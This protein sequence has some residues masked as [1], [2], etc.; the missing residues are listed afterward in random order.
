[1]DDDI[2]AIRRVLGVQFVYVQAWGRAAENDHL[3]L[4]VAVDVVKPSVRRFA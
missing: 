4:A 2:V 3:G 1:M